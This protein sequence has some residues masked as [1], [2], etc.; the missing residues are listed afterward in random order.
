MV[1]TDPPYNV[2]YEGKTSDALK[3]ENDQMEDGT[4][5]QFL[6]DIFT[7]AYTVT[8][9]GGPI[10]VAHADSEGVNFREALTEAGFL[11]KQCIIWVKNTMVLGRQD[12][13][14]QHEPILYGWKPGAAHKW[15]GEFNKKTV[16]DDTPSLKDMDKSELLAEAKRLRNALNASV[17]L[18]DKPSRSGEHPTMK[19]VGLILH[20]L[21]NSS[22]RGNAVLD[23]CGGS[24]STLIAAQKTGRH[25]RLMEIDPRYCDVIV[26]R[27]QEYTGTPGV[28][29]ATGQAFDAISPKAA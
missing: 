29:E 23:L 14:W 1:W 15:Y 11:F 20:M 17:V 18:E 2:D 7:S 6:R 12:Y 25:A 8:R 10:Y 4:F 16:I 27:F 26:R 5:R 9:E 28:L 19:P 13:Q 22:V 3:I 21:K 24:G